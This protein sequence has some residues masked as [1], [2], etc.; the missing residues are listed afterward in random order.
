MSGNR[1]IFAEGV[2]FDAVP[3]AFAREPNLSHGAK[4]VLLLAMSHDESWVWRAAQLRK[5]LRIKRRETMAKYNREL[6]AFGCYRLSKYSEDGKIKTAVVY[7][8]GRF[9]RGDSE[10]DNTFGDVIDDAE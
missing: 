8:W 3:R 10:F 6:E 1:R 5:T 2:R 7:S 9:A 4:A